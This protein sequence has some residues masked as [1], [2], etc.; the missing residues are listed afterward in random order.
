MKE[1]KAE[2]LGLRPIGYITGFASAGV[3]PARMGIGPYYASAKLFEKTGMEFKDF[4]LIEINEAF[5]A[6]VL[7]VVK[8]FE[9]P[10]YAKTNLE[11]GTSLGVIDLD[12]LNVNGGA[13]SLGHPLGASGARL[14]YTLIKELNRARIKTWTG[15]ALC[16]RRPR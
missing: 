6:Q 10:E 14:V 2:Q 7:A 4:D 8:A 9:N 15:D 11:R 5:A 16:W 13:I 12:R 3:D 1:S